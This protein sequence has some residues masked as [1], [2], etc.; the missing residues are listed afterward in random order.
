[1]ELETIVANA[2]KDE[3]G[4]RVLYEHTAD[5]VF[6]YLLSRVRDR[7]QASELMQDVFVSLWKSIGRLHYR[8]D[9]EFYGYMFTIVRREVS[10][11]RRSMKDTVSIEECYDIP[12]DDAAPE[13]YRHL[14]RVVESLPEKQR[15][16]ITLRYFSDLPFQ[17]IA[18]MLGITE[19][20]AKVIHHR[21]VELL[22][23]TLATYE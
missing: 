22:H 6:A 4:F 18:A 3:A 9:A 21:A 7:Q 2:K 5:M 11:A 1:M 10:R 13:D 12:S 14:L 20:N 16:V 8:S 19:N 17:E 23:T 15:L